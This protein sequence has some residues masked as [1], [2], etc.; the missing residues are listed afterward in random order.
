MGKL[1]YDTREEIDRYISLFEKY[2]IVG[3]KYESKL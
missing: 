1:Q 3:S 2:E